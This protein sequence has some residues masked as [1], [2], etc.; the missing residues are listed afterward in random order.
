MA[1]AVVNQGEGIFLTNVV[2]KAAPENLVLRLYSNNLTPSDTNIETDYTEL[3]G[4]NGYAAITLNGASWNAPVEGDPT[5][6]DYAKQT[7]TFTGAEGNVY[8]YYL[9]QV[10]SGKLIM[11]ERFTAAPYNIVNNGDKIEITPKIGAD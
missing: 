7:F 9:T 11:A 4:A 3:T 8:G 1:F 10:T 6:I 5:Y 2:N